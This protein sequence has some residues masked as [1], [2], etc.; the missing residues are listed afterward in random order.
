VLEEYKQQITVEQCFPVVKDPKLVGA[1]YLKNGQRI[2]A[3]EYGWSW[4]CW[5]IR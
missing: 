2:E 4:H 3:L 5:C 1:V